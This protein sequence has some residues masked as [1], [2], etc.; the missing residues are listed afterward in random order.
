M[1][2]EQ[3]RCTVKENRP[4]D[5]RVVDDL[6]LKVEPIGRDGTGKQHL[7]H[8]KELCRFENVKGSMALT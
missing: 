6:S 1:L 5:R 8:V 3:L 4:L 7:W 2:A